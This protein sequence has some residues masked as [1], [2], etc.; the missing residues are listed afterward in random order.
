MSHSK[1]LLKPPFT[2]TYIILFCIELEYKTFLL[3]FFLLICLYPLLKMICCE[4]TWHTIIALSKG[5]L[6]FYGV[7][8][9]MLI[10][11]TQ[12]SAIPSCC[13]LTRYLRERFLMSTVRKW[14]E[15]IHAWYFFIWTTGTVTFIFKNLSWLVWFP[16]GNLKHC[17]QI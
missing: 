5:R 16:W 12:Y 4:K 2:K 17:F 11:R 15:L 13:I 6:L 8:L 7:C 3:I 1:C 9:R 14:N 10:K